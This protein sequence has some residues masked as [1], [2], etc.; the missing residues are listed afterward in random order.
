MY[1]LTKTPDFRPYLVLLWLLLLA[2]CATT[3]DDLKPS[4]SG[5]S[6]SGKASYYADSLHGNVTAN[7]EKFNQHALTAAHRK[8]PFGTK[9][10]V[11]NKANGKSV[12]VR[13]NDRGP[14]V[15]GRVID[16]SKAA[17]QRIGNPKV[18]LLSVRIDA[19]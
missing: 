17:F 2:S 6:Q 7:G 13:I 15:Q 3:D 11:T 19:L 10:K 1:C 16:L 18:G 9:V 5:F 8:L 4:S 14:F 12:V